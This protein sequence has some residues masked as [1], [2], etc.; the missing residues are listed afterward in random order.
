PPPQTRT[1]GGETLPRLDPERV[2]G[3]ELAAAAEAVL[4][5]G[6][7]PRSRGRRPPVVMA[8]LTEHVAGWSR[9][10]AAEALARAELPLDLPPDSARHGERRAVAVRELAPLQT[11]REWQPTL[12]Y[13]PADGQLRDGAVYTPRRFPEAELRQAAGVND[14]LAAYFAGAEWRG[15]VEGAKGELR[16][17]LQTQHDRC[18]RKAEVLAG[19][20]AALEEAQQLRL[21]AD[22][23]LA[24]QSAV[25]P[26]TSSF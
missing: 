24:F 4:M 8:A 6:E 21:E 13:G 25:P 11:T 17:L 5:R 12:V 26:G 10:L 1:L 15:A 9:D 23:L 7:L 20:L 18:R 19:E 22:L 2:T 3:D 14:L 16:H